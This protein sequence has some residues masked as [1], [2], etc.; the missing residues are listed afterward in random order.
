MLHSIVKLLKKSTLFLKTPRNVF[1]FSLTDQKNQ[2]FPMQICIPSHRKILRHRKIYLNVKVT[3][4]EL[5]NYFMV[6]AIQFGTS[7]S[8]FMIPYF[9]YGDKI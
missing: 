5:G 2:S 4:I 3:D 6:S 1:F 9:C 7:F 8:K